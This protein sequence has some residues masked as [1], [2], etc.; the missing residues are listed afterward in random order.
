M[1][2]ITVK[3]KRL[4]VPC[5]GEKEMSGV[6]A[7]QGD[8]LFVK[9]QAQGLVIKLFSLRRGMDKSEIS[10]ATSS[11]ISFFIEGSPMISL[12]AFA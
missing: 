10:K 11:M 12:L 4:T 8:S 5:L 7:S 9:D 2:E 3:A 6:C 1:R